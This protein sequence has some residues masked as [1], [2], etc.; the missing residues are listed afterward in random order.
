[1]V[2]ARRLAA[3]AAASVVGAILVAGVASAGAQQQ[4]GGP[5][6]PSQ[7]GQSAA[8]GGAA[9]PSTA[10]TVLDPPEVQQ[11]ARDGLVI[12]AE[13]AAILDRLQAFASPKPP[14]VSDLVTAVDLGFPTRAARPAP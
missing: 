12:V 8:G 14:P 6:Q 4:P 2:R 7:P 1:M 3:V 11:A 5:S 13:K 10:S 9:A